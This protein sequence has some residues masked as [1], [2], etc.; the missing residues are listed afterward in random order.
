MTLDHEISIG[1][2]SERTGVARSALRFY[3]DEGLVHSRR[4]SGNQRRYHRDTVRRVSF[5]RVAQELGMTLEEIRGAMADL[6]EERTPTKADWARIS[7]N[8]RPRIDAQIEMLERL[9][10]RL[11]SCIGCGCLSMRA[12]RLMNPDDE[13]AQDGPGPRYLLVEE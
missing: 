9:R 10:D 12:C 8:W 11:D 4:T 6:P 2:L 1:D 13:A 5:I 3:E 7:R